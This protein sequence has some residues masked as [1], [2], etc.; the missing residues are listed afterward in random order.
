VNLDRSKYNSRSHAL[1]QII[2]T[3]LAEMMLNTLKVPLLLLVGLGSLSVASATLGEIACSSPLFK[4]LPWCKKAQPSQKLSIT[5]KLFAL[6]REFTPD[7]YALID[8]KLPVV[9]KLLEAHYED[10]PLKATNARLEEM[11]VDYKA[12]SESVPIDEYS[13]TFTHTAVTSKLFNFKEFMD[14]KVPIIQQ[15]LTQAVVSKAPQTKLLEESALYTL[16]AGGKRIRPLLCLAAFEMF[17]DEDSSVALPTAVSSELI[18]TM[19]LM[20]DDLPSIDNDALR[21]GGK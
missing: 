2:D 19:S 21:R 13:E 6:C 10:S 8:E 5:Q 1:S 18:H 12:L 15:A 11:A 4:W 14:A 9:E 7:V 17:S 20:T 3:Q 16:M